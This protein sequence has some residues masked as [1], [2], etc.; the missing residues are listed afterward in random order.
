M[1]VDE[2]LARLIREAEELLR[3]AE[4]LAAEERRLDA[5]NRAMLEI[6]IPQRNARAKRSD[7]SN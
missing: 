4:E 5:I 3:I 6:P 7:H 1:S 2:E